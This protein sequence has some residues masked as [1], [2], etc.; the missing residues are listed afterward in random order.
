MLFLIFVLKVGVDVFFLLD[1]VVKWC[2]IEFLLFL[3]NGFFLLDGIVGLFLNVLWF[4]F[5]DN[6]FFLVLFV[7][8][9]E[10]VLL[11]GLVEYFFVLYG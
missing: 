9:W 11:F 10:Y 5:G 6:V 1:D 8:V 7:F 4:V 3:N 2:L